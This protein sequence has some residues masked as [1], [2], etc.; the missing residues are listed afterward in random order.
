M[1]TLWQTTDPKT[2]LAFDRKNNIGLHH[3]ALRVKNSE[4]L[5]KLY[6]RLLNT[7]NVKIEFSPEQLGNSSSRHMMSIVTE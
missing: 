4:T 2:A 3:L 1:L 5:D 6:Q 7:D